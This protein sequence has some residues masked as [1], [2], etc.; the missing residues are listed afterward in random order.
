[1]KFLDFSSVLNEKIEQIYRFLI[2][3]STLTIFYDDATFKLFQL[4]FN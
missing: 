4:F 1:M 2:K 3:Y